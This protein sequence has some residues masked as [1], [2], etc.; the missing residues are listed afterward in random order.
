MRCQ[1]CG[2]QNESDSRFCGGC[3]ARLGG[4]LAPTQKI[5]DE[6]PTS[7]Q[8]AVRTSAPVPVQSIALPGTTTTP[9]TKPAAA[10][11]SAASPRSVSS[12]P[13]A[14]A[15]EPS[16]A[17]PSLRPPPSAVQPVPQMSSSAPVVAP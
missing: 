3:G 17:Q 6:R 2:T 10:R 14:Y 4:T 12:A 1:S 11:S 9:G 7:Q 13:G 8:G 16:A 15:S 5:L